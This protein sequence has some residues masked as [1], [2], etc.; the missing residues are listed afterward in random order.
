MQTAQNLTP[1]HLQLH[2][3][4]KARQERFRKAGIHYQ[5]PESKQIALEDLRRE[6][7]AKEKRRKQL[8]KPWFQ[9]SWENMVELAISIKHGAKITP[10]LMPPPP[11]YKKILTEVCEKHKISRHE[12]ESPRRNKY[13]VLARRELS[14]RC[15]KETD[16][17]FPEIGRRMGGRDH[18]TILNQESE[19]RRLLAVKAGDKSKLKYQDRHINWDLVE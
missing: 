18:T 7:E 3:A 8:A 10:V 15:R 5:G 11:K 6:R 14:Y 17:S 16:L 4:H 1:Y 2:L 13:I 12:L 19:W 9:K